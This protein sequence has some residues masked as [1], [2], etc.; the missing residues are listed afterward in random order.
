LR[1]GSAGS[2]SA[3][4]LAAELFKSM[5][6]IEVTHVPYKG[7]SQ[8]IVDVLSRQIDFMFD[9]IPNSMQHIKAGRLRGLGVSGA[10]RSPLM[11]DLPTIAEAGVPDYEASTWF[12]V[13]APAGTPHESVERLSA[14]SQK[15]AA[16][17]DLKRRMLSLGL[18]PVGNSSDQFAQLIRL[19]L[20]KWARVV[21]ASGAK[22]D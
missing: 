12:G 11:R 19:E 22:V 2:G 1:F 8:A 13:L 14:A 16:S 18:E 20:P 10:Q 5:A 4:H 21:Q 3:T 15:A 6:R 9:T 7:G 17:D